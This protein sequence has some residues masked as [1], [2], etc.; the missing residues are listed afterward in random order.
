[1][2]TTFDI[3]LA[4]SPKDSNKLKYVLESIA[5]NISGFN[6]IIICSP[7]EL[8]HEHFSSLPVIYYLDKDGLPGVDRSKWMFRPN[9]C[10]QQHLK[11]FQKLTSDWYLTLDCD[12]IIN[13]KLNFFENEKPIYYYGADQFHVPYFTFMKEML[14]LSRVGGKSYIADMNFIYRPIIEDLL[15]NNDF[16][17]GTF[18]QKSQQITEKNCHI[19]EPEIYGN[20]CFKNYSGFY[21]ERELKQAPL[22]G[23]MQNQM[24]ILNW[25][26]NEI[27]KIIRG[28]KNYDFDTFSIHSW[29]DEGDQ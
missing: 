28:M 1:M 16:D 6:N 23:K 10:F 19:G 29:L 11:L 21:V 3:F 12:T 13:R 27:E 18:I 4:C 15:K 2:S 26:K 5:N 8:N 24:E 9:W 14:N 22:Q 25:N 17:R 20:Y 7:I